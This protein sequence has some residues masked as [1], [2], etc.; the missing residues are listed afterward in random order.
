MTAL[1]AVEDAEREE[2]QARIKA[3]ATA[4]VESQNVASEAVTQATQWVK[5]WLKRHA[6]DGVVSVYCPWV[7]DMQLETSMSI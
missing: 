7:K 4:Q 1:V 6:S 5:E 2:I 3:A